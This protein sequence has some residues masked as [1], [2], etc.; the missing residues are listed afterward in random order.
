[1]RSVQERRFSGLWVLLCFLLPVTLL[2][3][4]CS[5]AEVNSAGRTL[6]EDSDLN[7]SL[8]LNGL[9]DDVPPAFQGATASTSVWLLVINVTWLDI[10]II[11]VI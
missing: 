10:Y 1:M 9:Q 11:I 2:W 3:V 7:H 6:T 5:Q 8:S 4:C